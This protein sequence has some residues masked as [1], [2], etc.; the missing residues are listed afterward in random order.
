MNKDDENFTS[1]YELFSTTIE[2]LLVIGRMGVLV[3][4]QHELAVPVIYKCENILCWK[5]TNGIL[6]EVILQEYN[7]DDQLEEIEIKYRLYLDKG[8]YT[9]DKYVDDHFEKTIVPNYKGSVLPF[10][11][12]VCGTIKGLSFNIFKSPILDIVDLNL[13]HYRTSADY[14]HALHFVAMPTPVIT[15]VSSADP[16]KIGATAIVLPN[17]NAKAYYLE[18]V[19]QG[20][21]SLEKALDKKQAQM[22]TF[23][24]RIQDTSTKGSEAEGIVKLRYSSDNA[25]LFD[26]AVMTELILNSVCNIIAHWMEINVVSNIALDKDFIESKLSANELSSLTNALLSGTID[27][28]TFIYNLKKGKMIAV[29]HDMKIN[30]QRSEQPNTNTNSEEEGNG[31]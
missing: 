27:E 9:V 19:G 16:V 13:S 25:T 6:S 28:E 5:Y 8:V 26:I 21:N 4:I 18:F 17:E 20:I 2:E 31:N 1:L 30:I 3:D 24:A 15:G 12:F 14:E 10:I 11:P 29:D 23:S 7:Y 22:S